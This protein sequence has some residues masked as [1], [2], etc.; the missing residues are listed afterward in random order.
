MH[1]SPPPAPWAAYRRLWPFLRPYLPRLPAVVLVSLAATG[2]SLAQPYISKLMIDGALLRHDMGVLWQVAALML[3]A[4]VG[5]YILNILAS[6]L[7]VSLSAAMLF[8]IRLAVLSHLQTLSPRFFGR[9]RLGDLMS[10]LNS[11]VSDIQRVAGDT[12]LAALANLL[13]LLGSVGLMLWLDWRLFV[14]GV[15]LVPLAVGA[16]LRAQKRLTDLSRQ[17]REA[18]ATIGS[19]LVDTIMC[20]RTVVALG[21][22]QHERD[23]FATAN[24]G[25]VSAMLRMQITSFL[26]GAVPGTL[27]S[28]STAGAMLWGGY[29]ITAG[30]MT[31]GTLVAFLA[32]Q[33]RLFAP[34]QGLLGLSATLAQ[35]R[36]ALARIF[37][38]MDTPPEVVEAENP[39][40]L[41]AIAREIR[42]DRVSLSHGRHP[43]LR[44]ASF[45]I[46]AG[47]FCAILGPS[48]A[49]KSTMADLMV[50]LLD[51]DGGQVLIDGG[52]LR[53]VALG[54]LRR[55]LLLVEQTPFLFNATL[56]A[57]IAFGLPDPGREAVL[58]AAQDAGLE[59]LLAR[60]PQGLAT[61][62]GE[63]GLALSAGE[64]QRVA[65]A[66]ALLRQPSAL[67]LDEPT[68][69]L[70]GE[71]EALIAASLRRAL[72]KA[73]LIVITHKP[74]LAAMA[75]ITVTLRDGI[76][77]HG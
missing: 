9:F 40:P 54:D 51:P 8:D 62:V 18:G 48:G 38:L 24:A 52:D 77:T 4:T 72:P 35:T 41:P 22:Q 45:T 49:G 19:L 27:L 69:A 20:M 29:E 3:G 75:D 59:P 31:I 47:R 12:L 63:R 42:F 46:P 58:R 67:I 68:A 37:E 13:F 26:S 6:W 32:Y 76:T 64:R 25:F 55:A 39:L 21:A 43:I 71:T 28:A 65:L 60:L 74:A 50:R 5:S 2:L 30:R 56:Y 36:V 17:M 33:Q 1:G 11:D 14:V 10:R 66:R 16:F 34:I 7:H 23:S 73:T 70:D 44:D 15:V 57:N 53:A 61:P